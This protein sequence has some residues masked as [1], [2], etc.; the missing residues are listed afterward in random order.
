M[1]RRAENDH[2]Y[3]GGLFSAVFKFMG[4]IGSS[5]E[6]WGRDG[7]YV[8]AV[9]MRSRCGCSSWRLW[10]RDRS[11]L[12]SALRFGNSCKDKGVS[13]NGP[14]DLDEQSDA[15]FI[16]NGSEPRKCVP[17]PAIVEPKAGGPQ[18]RDGDILSVT[19]TSI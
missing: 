5:V 18:P 15:Y 16:L 14:A 6:S 3:G 7:I 11:P 8:T 10:V 19:S 1:K 9:V 2:I 4:L 12:S 17:I 13:W